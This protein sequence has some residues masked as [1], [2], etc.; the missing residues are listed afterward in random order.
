MKKELK[1]EGLESD[2]NKAFNRAILREVGT[3]PCRD[4]NIKDQLSFCVVI[5]YQE[6]FIL[7]VQVSVTLG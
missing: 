2:L 6:E 3:M 5:S 4:C 7:S 1:R